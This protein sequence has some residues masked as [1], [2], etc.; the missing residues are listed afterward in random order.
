M[1]KKII[2]IALGKANPE[3]PNGVNKV[4]NS[5]V[6]HQ[7]CNGFNAEFWGISF[8]NKHNY[9]NRNYRTNLF[10]D[11]RLKFRLDKALE[12]AINK[13]NPQKTIF[14]IHGAFIPQFYTLSRLLKK[15]KIPYF[16]TPHGGYNIKALKRSK[17]T[18]LIYTAL[19][20]RPLVNKAQGV[21]L[22]GASEFVGAK[23]HFTNSFSLIPNGQ[24]LNKEIPALKKEKKSI[25]LGFIGRIDIETKGLDILLNG[26]RKAAQHNDIKLEIVGSGGEIASLKQM[27]EK[28]G[29]NQ[30]VTFKGAIY[31]DDK[32]TVISNWDAL[33][34]TSRNEGIPGV[35]LEAASVGVP[36]IVSKETN[37]GKYVKNYASGWVLEQNS[38]ECLFDAIQELE[39]S[40]TTG[41][42]KNYK[43]AAQTMIRKEFDWNLIAKKLVA[44]Y[45][46]Q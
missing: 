32:L 43:H 37:M 40:K 33:C 2:H 20:E 17:W 15:R 12:E 4:V 14:H 7:V 34:L 18:K 13:L 8:S 10:M 38:P 44:A 21:Q 31:G 29:L 28:L 24:E 39:L 45:D 6:S 41:A 46:K 26:I 30:H 36:S 35:V 9:P 42:Y 23:K 11:Q 5:L 1:N 22:L 27:V 3:R 16:F 25:L 19:F